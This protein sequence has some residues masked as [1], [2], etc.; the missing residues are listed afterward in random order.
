M[1]KET[2]Q[3]SQHSVRVFGFGK[4]KTGQGQGLGVCVKFLG[5]KDGW[6]GHGSSKEKEKG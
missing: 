3:Q 5:Q 1:H 4:R 2:M 6:L